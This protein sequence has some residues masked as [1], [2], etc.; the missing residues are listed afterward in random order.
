MIKV[1]DAI[2]ELNDVLGNKTIDINHLINNG[3]CKISEIFEDDFIE[4]FILSGV[5]RYF[6][7]EERLTPEILIQLLYTIFDTKSLIIDSN[8]IGD[9]QKLKDLLYKNYR[10]NIIGDSFWDVLDKINKWYH[11][12]IGTMFR[13]LDSLLRLDAASTSDNLEEIEIDQ[14][15]DM[16]I[17]NKIDPYKYYEII[18]HIPDHEKSVA[19]VI[20][21]RS[22]TVKDRIDFINSIKYTTKLENEL[23]RVL[24]DKMTSLD[25]MEVIL[26]K[27]RK[28]KERIYTDIIFGSRNINSSFKNNFRIMNMKQSK[29]F[30]RKHQDDILEIMIKPY[31]NRYENTIS[32][33]IFIPLTFFITGLMSVYIEDKEP[34]KLKELFKLDKFS[35]IMLFKNQ[36]HRIINIDDYIDD[37]EFNND[38]KISSSSMD[39][40]ISSTVL[41]NA[42]GDDELMGIYLNQIVYNIDSDNMNTLF[43]QQIV[44]R[45]NKDMYYVFNEIYDNGI[46]KINEYNVDAF[47]YAT[48]YRFYMT[49]LSN[50]NSMANNSGEEPKYTYNGIDIDLISPKVNNRFVFRSSQV[51]PDPDYYIENVKYAYFNMGKLLTDITNI[52]GSDIIR[53]MERVNMYTHNNTNIRVGLHDETIENVIIIL[54]SILH[55]L[56]NGIELS[57]VEIGYLNIL[58]NS[59]STDYLTDELV[60]YIDRINSNTGRYHK[61]L[62]SY[63]TSFGSSIY[64]NCI[65][66]AFK[67]G[68]VDVDIKDYYDKTLLIFKVLYAYEVAH[69]ISE[70]INY[71]NKNIISD[72]RSVLKLII[73]DI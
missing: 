43:S 46:I 24:R 3:Y 14:Y 52:Y 21:N 62:D 55:G 28:S 36:F 27:S 64:M 33:R 9:I 18:K 54:I 34:D 67:T 23:I 40:K 5:L 53:Y 38:D 66:Q 20:S 63:S 71:K 58:L 60:K 11:P 6:E 32:D 15:L 29:P 35:M 65:I 49:L 17:R 68:L 16:F 26:D 10:K 39:L 2:S 42:L 4:N 37:Q 25:L 70:L 50:S 1:V 56:N 45:T 47:K 61:K 48:Q 30:I 41:S 13:E 19:E 72:K 12:G 51:M 59:L 57:N 8:N 22:L 7:R 31:I 69:I 73:T 44:K